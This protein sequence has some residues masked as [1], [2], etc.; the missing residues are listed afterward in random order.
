MLGFEVKLM[1]FHQCGVILTKFHFNMFSTDDDEE[2]GEAALGEL[3]RDEACTVAHMVCTKP[4]GTS[5]PAP[6]MG[7]TIVTDQLLGPTFIC[8]TPDMG[9]YVKSLR[10][11]KEIF[12][13]G[14]RLCQ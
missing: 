5:L 2:A 14:F 6:V 11:E 13:E 4:S 10:Y 7:I 1:W 12:I 8:L 3:T 9:C